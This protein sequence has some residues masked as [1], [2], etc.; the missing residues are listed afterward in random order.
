MS[1][2]PRST[3][4]WREAVR[5]TPRARF[6]YLETM[7]LPVRIGPA[8]TMARGRRRSAIAALIALALPCAALASAQA[9]AVDEEAP[10][11]TWSSPELGLRLTPPPYW[12]RMIAELPEPLVL[13]PPGR[14]GHV[15]ILALPLPPG[16]ADLAALTDRAVSSLAE[17]VRK[18]KLLSRREVE[19][20]DQPASEIY[21][22]GKIDK[23]E[24]RWVQT[25]F[26]WKDHQIL[27][28][29]TAP[30]ERYLHYLGDYDQILRSIRLRP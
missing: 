14:S 1:W 20:D 19:I 5:L 25:L 15:A 17:N 2:F 16:S 7:E 30:A 4:P 9:D 29:Y 22:R 21:F 3:D 18:F 13:S 11:E 28:T 6:P 24:Y 12:Q 23:N 27:L 8:L 10:P 26:V